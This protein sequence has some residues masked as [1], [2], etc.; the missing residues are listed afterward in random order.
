MFIVCVC[1]LNRTS[2]CLAEFFEGLRFGSYSAGLCDGTNTRS[3]GNSKITGF[4]QI[5]TD[6]WWQIRRFWL[7]IHSLPRKDLP[8]DIPGQAYQI[9]NLRQIW[10]TQSKHVQT[11]CFVGNLSDSHSNLGKVSNLQAEVG[12]ARLFVSGRENPFLLTPC[13]AAVCTVQPQ[14]LAARMRNAHQKTHHDVHHS[15]E[16][17]NPEH[18]APD[19]MP[20]AMY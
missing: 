4:C 15:N 7:Q 11:V 3:V 17:R 12:I 16:I 6:F 1:V 10:F 8:Q 20:I 13:A 9:F 19:H 5:C 14:Q 18:H 2:N